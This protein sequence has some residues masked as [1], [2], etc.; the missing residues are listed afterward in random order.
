MADVAVVVVTWNSERHIGACLQSL[1]AQGADLD[2]VVVDNA[3]SDQTLDVVAEVAPRARVL[4]NATNVGLAAAN[5]QGIEAT[6][7]PVVV[8]S[9]PDVT[10]RPGAVQALA[11]A[12]ERHPRAAFAFA[13]LLDPDGSVQTAAG[14]LPTLR[15]AL[16]GRRH[17]GD[18]GFWWHGWA[19]DEERRI[20]HGGEACYAVRREA[21]ADIGLQDPRYRLDWEGI[22]WAARA[23]EMGWEAW[24]CPA[25]E[26]VHVGGASLRQVPFRWIARSHAGMYRYFSRRRSPVARPAIA[27]VVGAR[28]LVKLA[29]AAVGAARYDRDHVPDGP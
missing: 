22:D 28:A 13:R 18:A 27:A 19:H 8:L 21:L 20:G 7:A 14:D 26:V 1:D 4:A 24:F 25:A 9:N 5:N 12:L 2:V 6:T 16:V 17:A 15:Q 3:S 29:L 23:A 10:Y 11:D